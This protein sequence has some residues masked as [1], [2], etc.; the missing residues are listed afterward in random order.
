LCPNI[1]WGEYDFDKI[2]ESGRE[3]LGEKESEAA[4]VAQQAEGIPAKWGEDMSGYL[5]DLSKIWLDSQK[6]CIGQLDRKASI[7]NDSYV[8]FI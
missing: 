6:R 4:K 1:R 2:F 5:L 7:S 8:N 3:E